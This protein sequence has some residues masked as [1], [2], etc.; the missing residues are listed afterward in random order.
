MRTRSCARRLFADR[1]L[2]VAAAIA[3]LAGAS[4][5]ARAQLVSSSGDVSPVFV[6]APVVDLTGQR[7]F[8]GFTTAGVGTLGSLSITGGGSLTAAQ[9]V[10][11]IGG[12]GVGTVSG[13]LMPA[14]A[15][16]LSTAFYVSL[17]F[18]FVDCF[19]TDDVD[20]QP[21]PD[22]DAPSTRPLP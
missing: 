9:I 3:L 15:L 17:W 21:P 5:P 10:P 8:L 13:L 16:F 11:G 1:P 22:I 2:A 4:L 19:G 20:S 18:S 14:F 12:L 6:A 7:I